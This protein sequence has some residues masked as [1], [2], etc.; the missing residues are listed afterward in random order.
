ME[1][2]PKVQ[3]IKSLRKLG[4]KVWIL[5]VGVWI[6][7]EHLNIPSQEGNGEIVTDQTTPSDISL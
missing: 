2:D 7:L 6:V 3:K 5:T 1:R 4:L